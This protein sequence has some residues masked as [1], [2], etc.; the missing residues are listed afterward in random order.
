MTWKKRTKK[1]MLPKG[2]NAPNYGE[3]GEFSPLNYTMMAGLRV[4]VQLCT[5]STVT[6]ITLIIVV[7]EMSLIE[8]KEVLL[9]CG[10]SY[11]NASLFF[12]L[13]GVNSCDYLKLLG[14]YKIAYDLILSVDS[15]DIVGVFV[16]EGLFALGE[17]EET[18][19]AEE[20]GPGVG[21]EHEGD[22]GN[23][24]QQVGYLGG[25]ELEFGLLDSY[26]KFV[27]EDE[28]PSNKNYETEEDIDEVEEETE[29]E[30]L[31]PETEE[32]LVD[33]NEKY[34]LVDL[35]AVGSE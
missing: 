13:G 28:G 7:D 23:E 31:P 14:S 16:A 9:E 11:D 22:E 27:E 8:L 18:G 17:R 26:D 25:N 29:N 21:E 15:D 4:T 32:L 5:M 10:I 34:P 33:H 3:I 24:G 6:L 20:V 1:F 35:Q 30:R 19:E 12:S 2:R